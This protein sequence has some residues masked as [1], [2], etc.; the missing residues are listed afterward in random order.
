[1]RTDPILRE[2]HELLLNQYGGQVRIIYVKKEEIGEPEPGPFVEELDIPGFLIHNLLSRGIKRLYKFQWEAI[3]SI[4]DGN[5]TVIVSGTGTGKTEAFLIPL[6]IKGISSSRNPCSLLLYPTKALARD[7]LKRINEIAGFG[8]ITTAVYDGD[9]PRKERKR[10]ASNPPNIL[11]SNPDMI[12]VGLV[13]SPAIR[14][15]VRNINYLVLDEMHSYEGAFGTHVR[16]IIERLKIFRRKDLV[17]V[18]SSATIGNPERH[19]EILFGEKVRVVRGPI[20]RRGIAYHVMISTGYLSR[21]SVSAAV[22]ALLSRLGLRVLVFVDSQQMAEVIA[23]IIHR[24]FNREFYVHRAGLMSEERRRIETMLSQGEIDGVVATPTL[25]LGIDIGYLDAIVMVAPPPSYAKYIQ[26]AGRAGRRG[27]IG[28]VFMVLGDDPIDSY[29]EKRPEEYFMRDIS[30]VYIEPGNEEVLRIHVIA[31]LLQQG[32]VKKDLVKR[33]GWEKVFDEIVNEG[34]AVSIPVGYFP[35]WRKARK[36]F[37]KY[38]TIRGAGPQVVIHDE[39]DEVIGFRELPMAVLDL[40]PYAIYLHGGRVY[41]SIMIDPD[42]RIARVR[43]LPDDTPLYTRPLYTTDLIDYDVIRERI[44]VRGIPLAYARVKISINVEGYAVYSIFESS[45]PAAIEYLDKPVI[46]T[47]KTRALLIKYPC[48]KEWNLMENAET[49]HAIEHTIISAARP[50]C[51][52]GLGD[53]GGISYPSGD[54]VVYDSAIGGSGLASLLFDR[55]EK[56]EE[57]AYR[58]MKECK[59]DDGCPRCIYSPYCGNNNKI[60]SRKKALFMLEKVISRKA[61]VHE[62]PVESKYGNPIA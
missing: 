52:A 56:A 44:S 55:F 47:Y 1:M 31:L 27:R 43:R 62:K 37:F 11:I 51:G 7:Q 17:F 45:R 21:W 48:I 49:F 18:G 3:K 41:Q 28:Y 39:N 5:N 34:F 33:F 61:Y 59:C 14:R 57:I 6:I 26:R 12:H 54:I 22:A 42:K 4:L 16:A 46:F 53:L 10:I 25:E 23:R 58:I 2:F 35:V 40:H 24:G 9:T 8:Y 15:M 19:G 38:M 30:P 60:L 36:E 32:M 29:Y 13:L 20:W 50:V